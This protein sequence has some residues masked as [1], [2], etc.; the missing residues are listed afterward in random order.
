MPS[1][2][3]WDTDPAYDTDSEDFGGVGPPLSEPGVAIKSDVPISRG[4][5]PAKPIPL[6]FTPQF[7]LNPIDVVHAVENVADE[8]RLGGCCGSNGLYGLN[9]RCHQ[10]GAEVGTLMEDCW[11][12]NVFIPQPCATDWVECE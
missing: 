9:Q 5:N 8:S 3:P 10:C 7:W 4:S 6:D 1:D 2:N 12:A 11:T